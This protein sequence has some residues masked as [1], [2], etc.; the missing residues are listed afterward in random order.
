MGLKKYKKAQPYYLKAIKILQQNTPN[1]YEGLLIHY[2]NLANAYYLDG[3][4]ESALDNFVISGEYCRKLYGNV[5]ENIRAEID[6]CNY[7]LK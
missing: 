7:H 3:N 1:D 5:S 6:K 2:Y 4:Y